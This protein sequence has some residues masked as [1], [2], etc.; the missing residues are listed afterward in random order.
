MGHVHQIEAKTLV[1]INNK[2]EK[3]RKVVLNKLCNIFA[4][5]IFKK[6]ENSDKILDEGLTK[7]VVLLYF[8]AFACNAKASQMPFFFSSYF[9]LFKDRLAKIAFVMFHGLLLACN[10]CLANFIGFTRKFLRGKCSLI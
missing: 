3:V 9:T 7:L 8:I 2:R 1:T 4:D 5:N 6:K 10:Q